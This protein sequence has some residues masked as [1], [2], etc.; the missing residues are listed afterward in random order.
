MQPAVALEDPGRSVCP[1]GLARRGLQA[2]VRPM[3]AGTVLPAAALLCAAG[4]ALAVEATFTA[5]GIRC[6]N[7]NFDANELSPSIFGANDYRLRRLL[8]LHA[9]AED[10]FARPDNLGC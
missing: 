10:L 5:D 6:G 9:R 4:P 1:P 7:T 8:I 3:K 2:G